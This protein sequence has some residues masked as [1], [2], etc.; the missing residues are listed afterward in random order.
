[1]Y[2]AT[3]KFNSCSSALDKAGQ[4]WHM[5]QKLTLPLAVVSVARPQ[6]PEI[7]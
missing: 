7:R 5:Y 1:M 4:I 3:T 6:Y 2:P